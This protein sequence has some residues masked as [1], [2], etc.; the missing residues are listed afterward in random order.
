MLV[1]IKTYLITGRCIPDIKTTQK[2]LCGK[3]TKIDLFMFTQPVQ[4]V[5]I[6]SVLKIESSSDISVLLIMSC[7]AF[8]TRVNYVN[9]LLRS[10]KKIILGLNF[11]RQS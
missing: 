11:F 7:D 6:H 5:L 8:I 4:M 1:L 2:A 9:N 10:F 3:R